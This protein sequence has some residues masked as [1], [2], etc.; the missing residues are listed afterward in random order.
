MSG[1]PVPPRGGGDRAPASLAALVARYHRSFNDRDFDVCREIFAPD[2][3][4]VIDGMP[5]RG[6]EAV[7]AYGAGATAEFPHLYIAEQRTVAEAADVV[8]TEIVLV[9]GDRGSGTARRWG[10]TCEIWRGRD[11]RVV[12]CRSYYMPETRDDDAVP[13]PARVEA[14]HLAQ[15]QTALL[16]VTTLVEKAASPEELFAAVT[17]E[18]G[19]LVGADPTTLTRIEPDDTLTLVAGWSAGAVALPIGMNQPMTAEL[20]RLCDRGRPW[21]WGPAPLPAAGPFVEEARALGVR[22][23][24]AVPVVVPGRVWGFAW[25]ASTGDRPLPDDVEAR[26]ARFTEL[27]ALA[28][29]NTESRAEL[30]ASRARLA[31][32]ADETRRQ[33]Q[34]DLHDGA[35]QRLVQ[36]ILTLKMAT[37]GSGDGREPA[38][39]LVDE[40]LA[41]AERALSELRALVRGVLPA[42]LTSDGLR[43]GIGSLT[44]SMSLPVSVEIPE[45]RL[46]VA[47][48]TSAYFVVAEAL[49]NVVKHAGASAARVR[50]VVDGTVLRVEVDDDGV[51]GATVGTGTGLVGLTD[52]VAAAGGRLTID[53]PPG[54]G[55]RLVAELP[56][57]A[58]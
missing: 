22:S 19:W 26:I 32:A 55:T 2:V 46:P 29:A 51:G 38:A 7:V 6:V 23:S 57:A 27:V 15:E 13:V 25:V 10:T 30:V 9:N 41:H 14:G 56:L 48:E 24:V 52:R 58:G 43:A 35:Q 47:V 37:T 28:I 33:I 11:G 31:T 54:R 44:E 50:A 40:A 39:E 34:R 4:L 3:D 21:R 49:T 42:T 45:E 16:Q 17:R 12:S 8:V 53:N 1:A 36:T 20:R 18:V 5:F